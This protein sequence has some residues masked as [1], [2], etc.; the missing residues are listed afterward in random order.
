M[1]KMSR[2]LVIGNGETPSKNFLMHQVRQ[3]DCILATDGGAN[4]ALACG[5]IPQVV[6]GDFDSLSA[7]TKKALKET[8][9]IFVDNQNN[10]DLEKALDYLTQKGF[11]STTLVGFLGGRWDFSIGNCL[12][13]YPYLNKT[14]ICFCA[15][16]WR[17]YPLRKGRKFTCSAKK[18]VSLI[19]LSPCKSLTI[20]GLKYPLK[21]VNLSRTRAGLTLSNETVG[22]AFEVQFERGFLLVYQEI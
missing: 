15:E 11:S 18:R 20:T 4:R 17:I 19:P 16:K 5:V 1:K 3:A 21:G 7:K 13:V 2:I 14:E 12:S 22:T 8:S 10:T 9:F 6:I